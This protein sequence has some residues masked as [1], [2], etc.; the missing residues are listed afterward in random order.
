MQE[1]NKKV[2]IIGGGFG[3][4]TA[5]QTFANKKGVDVLL[6]DR[7]NH[8][9]FQP[10]LYQV[11]TSAL[12]PGDIAT[13]IR[14]VF[15]GK[16]NVQVV[17]DEIIEVDK[18]KRQITGRSGKDYPYDYLIIATGTRHSYFGNP[19]WEKHAPGLKTL[20]D[21]LNI[22]ERILW[23]L[24]QAENEDDVELRQKYLNFVI[25][26]GGPTGVEL[27]G[28]ISEITRKTGMDDYKHVREKDIHVYLLEG[29]DA[30]LSTYPDEL[31][32]NARKKLVDM[33]VNVYLNTMVNDINDEGIKAGSL[34]I[35]SSNV[36]WAAGNEGTSLLKKL[37]FDTDRA[38]RIIVNSFLDTEDFP[39]IYVI[40]DAANCT[41]ADGKEVPGIAPAAMQ[42]GEFVA[43]KIMGNAQKNGGFVYRDKG[44]MATI[45]RGKAIAEI[46]GFKFKGFIAWLLWSFIHIFFLIGFR[47][48]FRVMAE[49]IW[50][51]L[52]FKGSFRL[53]TGRNKKDNK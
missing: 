8:H 35:P 30:V 40:G 31:S 38:G 24:E 27:A 36:I 49:W 53:I 46:G 4:L 23:S 5:A 43:K 32:E 11:A 52:T 21:A 12:S 1:S 19:D 3:G 50:Y 45:G 33:G 13:P 2:V 29:L 10:L 44:N 22:R 41:D 37:G 42:M 20:T 7:T 6:I 39:E 47:N 34:I 14:S 28:A 26:G 16:K 48:R 9:L 15:R 51:Y 25:I 17:M 18:S